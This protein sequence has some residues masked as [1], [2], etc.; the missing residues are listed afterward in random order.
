MDALPVYE[1][2]KR[3]GLAG[4]FLLKFFVSGLFL[5]TGTLWSVYFSKVIA[6]FF[7]LLWIY[8]I[9]A[10]SLNY[11]SK[12]K[13][14][15]VDDVVHVEVGGFTFKI[16]KQEARLRMESVASKNL[17]TYYIFLKK[18]D[19]LFPAVM[20]GKIAL[21]ATTDKTSVE[22]ELEHIEALTGIPGFDFRLH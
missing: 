19:R 17:I 20:M 4:I 18:A 15:L 3:N 8:C 21:F 16:P 7:L 10:Y 6:A 11:L 12:K 13:I 9:V 1:T 2:G 14:Y 5:L 22:N